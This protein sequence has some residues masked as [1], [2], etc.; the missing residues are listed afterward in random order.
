MSR[1]SAALLLAELPYRDPAW[2][3]DLLRQRAETVATATEDDVDTEGEAL[4]LARGDPLITLALAR[5]SLD[6]DRVAELFQRGGDLRTV[7]LTNRAW[8][9]TRLMRSLPGMLF[10][11]DEHRCATWLAEA[12][13]IDLLA[14]FENSTLDDDVAARVV[15]GQ[16]PYELVSDAQ[17]IRAVWGLSN[18][19]GLV[20]GALPEAQVSIGPAARAALWRAAASVEP[21]AGWAM[22]LAAAYE[23]LE[24][25]GRALDDPLAVADR[26]GED[27]P[28]S[29]SF[30]RL[31][32]RMHLVRMVL[33]ASGR[34]L[35]ELLA[36][37]DSAHRAAGL[38]WGAVSPEHIQT[39]IEQDA[40]FAVEHLVKNVRFWREAADRQAL[41]DWCVQA[42]ERTSGYLRPTDTFKE[43]ARWFRVRHPAWFGR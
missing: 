14:L 5:F 2:V 29:T 3:Y 36:S 4:L 10:E 21:S 25:D 16:Q 18:N 8:Y 27:G 42:N 20:A 26:W 40:V 28:H 33:E 34:G 23:N 7:A 30:P 13:E 37:P 32:V 11:D 24:P 6:G 9:F 39:A 15:L 19:P 43:A 31:T 17:R 1:V 35:P 41:W 38:R 12:P 22:A